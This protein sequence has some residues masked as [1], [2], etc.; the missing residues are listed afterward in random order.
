[1]SP[2][3]AGP[4]VGLMELATVVTGCVG[5]LAG[6][7]TGVYALTVEPPGQPR[8]PMRS[9][10]PGPAAGIALV[11]AVLSAATGYRF[12]WSW[13]LPVLAATAALAAPLA[14]TDVRVRRLPY[15]LMAPI[16]AVGVA[17]AALAIVFSSKP[18][19]A[20]RALLAMGVVGATALL[21]ALAAA[22]QFGLGDVV[23][24]GALAI[25]LGWLGWP[26][27]VVGIGSGLLLAAV[28]GAVSMIAG[29]LTWRDRMSLGPVLLA[30]WFAGVF[31]P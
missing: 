22:G 26:H 1:V 27:L 6:G 17:C 20:A 18:W 8:R 9:V 29:R 24:L 28:G 21:L 4:I 25:S 2:A 12:G 23:L 15:L 7:I 30:G 11:S 13:P 16:Y 31:G 14:V 19:D 5:A 10:G 3:R